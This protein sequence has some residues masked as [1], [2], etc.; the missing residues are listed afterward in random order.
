MGRGLFHR[1]RFAVLLLLAG[2]CAF[3]QAA[4]AQ[5]AI[6]V[7]S[8]EQDD[9]AHPPVPADVQH[10]ERKSET[11]ALAP[12][13]SLR[14]LVVYTPKAL[15]DLP[16]IHGAV[17]L[18]LDH[19][20]TTLAN[21]KI[22]LGARLVGMD[23]VDYTETATETSVSMLN[24]ATN[25]TGDFA[26]IAELRQAVKADIVIVFSH[27]V[28]DGNCGRGWQNDNLDGGAVS[29]AAGA[30]FGIN[31]V[32]ADLGNCAY[33]RSA[34]HETGHNLGA[35][36]DRYV[37]PGA[38]PGPASYNYGFVDVAARV[39]DMMAYPNECS[40]N[41]IRCARL[42][43]Y[44]SPDIIH[45]GKPLGVAASDPK[46]ADAARR[47][48]EIAPYVLRFGDALRA[49]TTP[50]LAVVASGSG[51]VTGGGIDCGPLC[52]ARAAVGAAVT[53]TAK[54]A[55][56]WRLKSWGG[57]CA[58][59]GG[60]TVSMSASQTV[61][62]TFT[63]SLHVGAVASTASTGNARS[64]LRF[65][66]TGTAAGTVSVILANPATGSELG[67]WISPPIP[68][69]AAREYPAA[70]MESA[71]VPGTP[72]PAAFAVTVEPAFSGAVQNLLRRADGALAN[73]STCDA[74][75]TTAPTRI[76]H[77]Q[78]SLPGNAATS[79]IVVA[80]AVRGNE[81]VDAGNHDVVA[82]TL[83]IFD[84]RDG[85]RLGA[86]VTAPIPRNGQAT[87]AVA[88][89]E[90]AAGITARADVPY[91]IVR[92]E[93][94]FSGYLQHVSTGAGVVSD[95]TTACAFEAVTPVF[96]TNAVVQPGPVF[97][98]RSFLRFFN[99]GAVAGAVDVTLADV[100]SG[101][102]L[103]QWTSPA[104]AP[105]AARQFAVSEI[106]RAV[107]SAPSYTALVQTQIAGTMQHVMWRAG[108]AVL[109]NASTCDAGVTS[110]ARQ[111]ANVHASAFADYPSSI[112]MTNTGA[113]A[114]AAIGLYDAATGSKL[115]AMTTAP[116]PAG[117]Q[118]TLSAAALE[119]AVGGVPTGT[120]HYV[121][122]LE[123]AFEGFLQHLVGNIRAGLT[124]DLSASCALPALS[125]RFDPCPADRPCA[126]ATGAEVVGQL[127]SQYTTDTYRVAL[128]QGR[129]YT[130]EI[131]GRDSSAGTL[132][133][134]RLQVYD[135]NLALTVTANGGG[136]GRDVKYVFTP[137]ATGAYTLVVSARE[138]GYA[139]EDDFKVIN[140]TTG[141]YR[142]SVG[143][144]GPRA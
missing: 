101:A 10:P 104:I 135:T 67:R 106:A 30:R 46:A 43:T 28:Y 121:V 78:A 62:A 14:L 122:K 93:S 130:V 76:T 83:G 68:P 8:E 73:L 19:I 72:L 61:F 119:A 127:K 81:T 124:T 102:V 82:V 107:P 57:A 31:V 95:L 141:T 37:L 100:A 16:D 36:H 94:A 59:E 110:T 3:P 55:P 35:A 92:V 51:T 74:G 85:A 18:V 111:L 125:V 91:Y 137:A 84:A 69:E 117:G 48:R 99:T 23:R 44:S 40:V 34:A 15:R 86:Y 47:I 33:A 45:N 11:L 54:A 129:P 136:A 9:T 71:I 53:L 12:G 126:L 27:W 50:I 103:G 128:V 65:A 113:T 134:P 75:V 143:D 38:V 49:P 26:R 88:D 109:S 112:V 96:D 17:A 70:L 32:S 25:G 118:F 7:D 79:S 56:G 97:P 41:G 64:V 39:R 87:V 133:A 21:S 114:A 1:W 29:A 63:P 90:R 89:M 131:R 24:A 13:A 66:N 142:I 140:P 80:Q 4:R 115:G 98:A 138:S 132:F 120:Q 77:V 6:S 60:C 2:L 5:I 139:E 108:D 144:G 42:L 116:I 22:A 58:G 20:N 123:S 105:G 52:S